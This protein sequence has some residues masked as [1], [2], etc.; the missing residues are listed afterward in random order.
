MNVHPIPTVNSEKNFQS[1]VYPLLSNII[2]HHSNPQCQEKITPENWI[3]RAN[4]KMPYGFLVKV[5]NWKQ[6]SSNW[7]AERIRS[8]TTKLP[9]RV[10]QITGEPLIRRSDDNEVTLKKRLSAY[11][12]Q[13]K[14]LVEYYKKRGLH[15]CIDAAES[16]DVVFRDVLREFERAKQRARKFF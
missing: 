10:P 12:S 15:S 1:F 4:C 14:P 6:A 5:E 8:S 16:P 7:L 2:L 9:F 3:V 11:H 13:T